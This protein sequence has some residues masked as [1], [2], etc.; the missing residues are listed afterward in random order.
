MLSAY[1]LFNRRI[2]KAGLIELPKLLEITLEHLTSH[3]MRKTAML[4][5]Y[6]EKLIFPSKIILFR[7]YEVIFSLVPVYHQGD[8]QD[9]FKQLYGNGDARA[10]K[11]S[12][13]YQ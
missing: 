1:P 10:V 9:A 7:L 3:D 13:H 4:L 5:E 2:Y 11:D 8:L 6:P 12:N